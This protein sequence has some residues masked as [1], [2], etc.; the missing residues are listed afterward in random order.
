M[1]FITY[2]SG[3]GAFVAV[4]AS[5]AP[6]GPS[7]ASLPQN[8]KYSAPAAAL[9]GEARKVYFEKT[10]IETIEAK[11]KARRTDDPNRPTPPESA[12]KILRDAFG[13]A[14]GAFTRH[15]DAFMRSRMRGAALAAYLSELYRATVPAADADMFA[16]DA[17]EEVACD[18][19]MAVAT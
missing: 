18:D 14:N 4:A 6:V 1:S 17:V 16:R 3:I 15:G 9:T 12:K 8:D 7:E 11:I 5:A 19:I 2:T 10:L 13:L